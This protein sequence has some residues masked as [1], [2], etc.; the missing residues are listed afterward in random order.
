MTVVP[1]RERIVVFEN[2][3]YV[4]DAS[5]SDSSVLGFVSLLTRWPVQ[6]LAIDE[7]RPPQQPRHHV[8]LAADENS[9][10]SGSSGSDVYVLVR[11]KSRILGGKG[12]F[13][14]LLK[15]QSRQAGANAT[16]NFG[17]CRDL[18]GRRLRHVN[19]AVA[20][21]QAR[22]WREK[23]KTGH[24]NEID[25]ARSIIETDS[26]VPG[27]Y[28]EL[29]AWSDIS[30]KEYRKWQR[31]FRYWKNEQEK[32]RRLKEEKRQQNDARIQHYVETANQATE[33]ARSSLKAALQEG[34]SKHKKQKQEQQI[35]EQQEQKQGSRELDDVDD[36]S[37]SDNLSAKRMKQQPDSPTALLTLSGDVVL[38]HHDE[39]DTWHVQSQS[40]FCTFG[41]VL[42]WDQFREQQQSNQFLQLYW[43]VKL[44]TGGL[45]QIGWAESNAQR[46][47]PNSETGDGVGDDVASYAY[48]GSRSI[49]LHRSESRSYGGSET[50]WNVGDTV[51]CS[52]D[53]KSGAISYSLNGKDLG[54]AFTIKPETTLYPAASCNPKEILELHLKESDMRF[55]PKSAVPIS[56]VLAVENV[57][58]E[59]NMEDDDNDNDDDEGNLE[60]DGNKP[61]ASTS[62]TDGKNNLLDA[63][64][65]TTPSSTVGPD[66]APP[67]PP[68]Q[69]IDLESI[70]SVS[71][72]EAMGLD[73]LKDALMALDVKCGG[74][75]LQR[76]ERLF[77]LK[78]LQRRDY[79]E[80]V[81]L[82]TKVRRNRKSDR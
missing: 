22:E 39:N 58:L 15:S 42:Q 59:E 82:A 63:S 45:S 70:N 23:L 43:E 34:L 38:A 71:E 10:S 26:R 65:S 55:L 14:S 44:I 81:L 3:H 20:A 16:T 73:R 5:S 21:A 37:C 48:D 68:P 46:F 72:L 57:R 18:Q 31:Q 78:G 29:P 25:Q 54:V 56:Q 4:V 6:L 60:D 28:L 62:S 32:E 40:N 49:L 75:L 61:N 1:E 17:A 35:Q 19:D 27:W 8:K 33:S 9:T 52:Y 11:R 67:P 69:V 64:S 51:G 77:S 53:T 30:K 36:S 7:Q 74:T 76:A 80:Q 47:Q 66:V 12:G 41:I 13:G 79:P 24:V 2:R 50:K